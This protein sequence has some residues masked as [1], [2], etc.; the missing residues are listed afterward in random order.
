MRYEDLAFRMRGLT[1]AGRV[2]PVGG[3][4]V[5]NELLGS[6]VNNSFFRIRLVGRFD[7]RVRVGTEFQKA[8]YG[9]SELAIET[10]FEA[11]EQVE[12]AG[13]VG[14]GAKCQSTDCVRIFIGHEGVEAASF[15]FHYGVFQFPD[16]GYQPVKMGH[17][18][19]DGVLGRGLG[20]VCA[21]EMVEDGDS[22]G[23][24]C[25]IGEKGFGAQTVAE[26][27]AGGVG[28][29]LG[30]DGPAG[31]GPV[32][33]RGGGAALG[34]GARGEH[35]AILCTGGWWIVVGEIAVGECF[36]LVTG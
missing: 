28:Y 35:L 22:F 1:R 32:G 23:F 10:G 19:D 24:G 16:A 29:A 12:G 14:E 8:A 26:A 21:H 31:F 7:H 9:A 25:G 11:V 27:V 36:Q 33:A 4:R 13:V 30:G 34:G 6:F 2:V 18:F 20:P 5:F 17:V 3:G 15:P